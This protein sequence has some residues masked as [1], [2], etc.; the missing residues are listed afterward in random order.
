[1][2]V[3]T[4]KLYF[5][6]GDKHTEP[7][8]A[9]REAL[10]LFKDQADAG[11]GLSLGGIEPVSP[12]LQEEGI[13]NHPELDADQ[14][15]GIREAQEKFAGGSGCYIAPLESEIDTERMAARIADFTRIAQQDDLTEPSSLTN[16]SPV[17]AF[18]ETSSLPAFF[19]GLKRHSGAAFNIAHPYTGGTVYDATD[20]SFYQVGD[21]KFEEAAD[22]D[23]PIFTLLLNT[24][25]VDGSL[26][27]ILSKSLLNRIPKG[28]DNMAPRHH[29]KSEPEYH[30]SGAESLLD[31][32]SSATCGGSILLR[33]RN[34]EEVNKQINRDVAELDEWGFSIA[35]E[36][37]NSSDV[38]VLFKMHPL[39]TDLKKLGPPFD[40]AHE[41]RKLDHTEWARANLPGYR[42][43]IAGDRTT[44]IDEFD[45]WRVLIEKP[46]RKDAED[47]IA[48]IEGPENEELEFDIDQAPFEEIFREVERNA[49]CEE[50][51][52]E[53]MQ[54]VHRI[55]RATDSGVSLTSAIAEMAENL[56]EHSSPD[57]LRYENRRA[58]LWL[59]ALVFIVEDINYRFNFHPIERGGPSYRKQGR[60][61]PMNAILQAIAT[62]DADMSEIADQSR[63]GN[64]PARP[65]Q[66]HGPD[67]LADWFNEHTLD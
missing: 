44:V 57:T 38:L 51:G 35:G 34:S 2:S 36:Y 16:I 27:T 62:L 50:S 15:T 49:R 59:L 58:F 41:R 61:Q 8:I 24:A 19:A 10:W 21:S 20:E 29:C 54:A 52:T 4:N 48:L 32:S 67:H 46:G 55:Y 18:W 37:T 26:D 6:A 39:H 12:G 53:F 3:G 40:A 9:R 63:G 14:V 17:G 45:G 66:F 22:A 65:D 47:F 31:V 33:Y 56:S 60:D 28:S 11:W 30:M 1:M 13:T 5:I 42:Q 43:G 25:E 7:D 64:L 23:G